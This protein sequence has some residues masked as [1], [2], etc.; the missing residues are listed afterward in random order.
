MTTTITRTVIDAYNLPSD[1]DSSYA[2]WLAFFGCEID[3]TVSLDTEVD[4]FN[5]YRQDYTLEVKLST[6]EVTG[7]FEDS[8]L[9][10]LA[11]SKH[12]EEAAERGIPEDVA[13]EMVRAIL[14]DVLTICIPVSSVNADP[15]AWEECYGDRV[16]SLGTQ[17]GILFVDDYLTLVETVNSAKRG[18]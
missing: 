10:D 13:R 16:L 2:T 15:L 14:G 4:L 12:L 8:D 9:F 11:Y 3:T 18:H 17:D 6:L 7:K 5:L 1:V